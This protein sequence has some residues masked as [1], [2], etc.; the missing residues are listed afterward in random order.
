MSLRY[1]PA[2][3]PLHI[4]VKWLVSNCHGCQVYDLLVFAEPVAPFRA[5][6]GIGDTLF[7]VSDL[8]TLE[9]SV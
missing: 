4:S 6:I 9:F 7:G 8:S 1:E 3:E 2:S 5:V